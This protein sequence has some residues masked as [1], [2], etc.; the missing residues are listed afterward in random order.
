[1]PLWNSSDQINWLTFADFYHEKR[2]QCGLIRAMLDA[3]GDA[4]LAG[5]EAAQR[6]ELQ[7]QLRYR[8]NGDSK[9]L[10]FLFMQ[11]PTTVHPQRIDIATGLEE[12]G[13]AARKENQMK[14]ENRMNVNI[15]KY[16]GTSG[17]SVALLLASGIPAL[18]KNSRTVTFS[19]DVVLNGTTLPAG[20]YTVQWETHSSGVTIEFVQRH[21]VVLTTD[22]GFVEH[23]K[24]YDRN[25]AASTASSLDGRTIA[26]DRDSVVYNTASD[27]TMSLVEI[28][29][30]YSNKVLVFDQQETPQ[31]KA[32]R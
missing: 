26:Y 27:G 10:G 14:K 28:R 16:L 18:A 2:I 15:R 9:W 4:P 24:G 29:F 25:M 31:L 22:G 21:K 8:V 32:A 1:M 20:Q 23:S 30:A 13:C 12:D 5:K 3:G 19:H 6:F 17:L 11:S 7:I